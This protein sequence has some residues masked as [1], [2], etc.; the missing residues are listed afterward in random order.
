MKI[1]KFFINLIPIKKVRKKLRQQYKAKQAIKKIKIAFYKSINPCTIF[2]I[3]DSHTDIFSKNRISEKISL[4]NKPE[5]ENMLMMN[6]T[7]AP[8]FVTYHIGACTAYATGKEHSSF[9]SKE[10]T[11]FLIKNGWLPPE[12]II[13]TVFGEIDCRVHIKK[14]AEKQNCP[15]D[16]IIDNIIHNYGEYLLFLKSQG[17]RVIAYGPIASQSDKA[18]FDPDFPRYGTEK[19]R[20]KITLLFNQKLKKFCQT[21]GI[22][23]FSVVDKLLNT[24]GT[25]KTEFYRDGVH[26]NNEALCFL[27]PKLIINST[28]GA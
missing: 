17:Y 25:T 23:Y 10:K 11:D 8:N 4:T 6:L 14:Q 27:N 18:P 28:K 21:N 2:V 5:L 19:E 26:L 3:G 15:E 7:D 13:L 12:A 22:G 9:H 24:D 16:K 1:K 20:N